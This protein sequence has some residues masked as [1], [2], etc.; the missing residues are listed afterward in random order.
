MKVLCLCAT[1]WNALHESFILGMETSIN[2]KMVCVL[3][4]RSNVNATINFAVNAKAQLIGWDDSKENLNEPF[5]YSLF[6]DT[7]TN[8]NMA[9]DFS[10]RE[11]VLIII[12]C[13]VCLGKWWQGSSHPFL[14]CWMSFVLIFHPGIAHEVEISSLN[15]FCW[16]PFGIATSPSI[17]HWLVCK[18]ICELVCSLVPQIQFTQT[19]FPPDAKLRIMHAFTWFVNR[20]I[21]NSAKSLERA[22]IAV[23][24]FAFQ[25]F[26]YFF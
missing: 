6:I 1:I 7:T 4:L 21:A 24:S 17:D 18:L 2:W 14:V 13:W 9:E 10:S 23:Q 8:L 16:S 3:M 11:K 26:N 20:K 15:S 19:Y 22:I 25:C 12:A 5:E